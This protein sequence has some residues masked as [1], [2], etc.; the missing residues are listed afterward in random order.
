MLDEAKVKDITGGDRLTARFLYGNLFTFQATS[1][2]WMYGNH[3][4][5]V[6]GADKGI[7]RRILLIPFDA[8]ITAEKRDNE[9]PQK[10][11]KELPGIL[12]WAVKGC[13]EWIEEG[14]SVPERILAATKEYREEQ[15]LI[16]HFLQE[17][18]TV[19][20]GARCG[21]QDLYDSYIKYMEDEGVHPLSQPKFRQR[22]LK[23]PGVTEDRTK[24]ARFWD[25]LTI[26]QEGAI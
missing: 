6:K 1:K 17:H 13:L 26:S 25:G 10:L 22:I 15:D 9:L 12:A 11:K 19:L 4:P 14:L 7:W 23:V 8:E 5:V 2:L 20:K 21:K 24:K 3:K 18:C 16:G